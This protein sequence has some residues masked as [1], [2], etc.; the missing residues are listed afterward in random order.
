M[1]VEMSFTTKYHN[2]PLVVNDDKN[3]KI[4]LCRRF[5]KTG[6]VITTSE[7]ISIV[8]IKCVAENKMPDPIILPVGTLNEDR[9]TKSSFTLGKCPIHGE[10]RFA[11]L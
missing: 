7:A 10:T 11:E 9:N 4:L 3:I 5:P 6:D 8:C 1:E 2:I